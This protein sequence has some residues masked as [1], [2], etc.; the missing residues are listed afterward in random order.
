MSTVVDNDKYIINGSTL[1]EIGD[2]VKGQMPKYEIVTED[3]VCYSYTPPAQQRY[4]VTLLNLTEETIQGWYQNTLPSPI[5]K[6]KIINTSKNPYGQDAYVKVDDGKKYFT[7][8]ESY[9]YSL[10]ITIRGGSTGSGIARYAFKI[11]PLNGDNYLFWD[12]NYYYPSSSSDYNDHLY[13]EEVSYERLLP[14]SNFLVSDIAQKI[15]SLPSLSVAQIDFIKMSS[16]GT[17]SSSTDGT[18]LLTTMGIKDI[19]DIYYIIGY[20]GYSHSYSSSLK[21]LVYLDMVNNPNPVKTSTYAG[22]TINYYQFYCLPQ[23]S[24]SSGQNPKAKPYVSW[25]YWK[26]QNCFLNDTSA[27]QKLAEDSNGYPAFVMVIHKPTSSS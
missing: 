11:Y 8:N 15:A 10:P 5:T 23:T 21:G 6:V 14:K 19:S 16:K 12:S 22:Q 20:N 17:Q 18:N 3:V 26:S 25:A 9:T 27:A 24:S 1:S 7:L 13:K 2:A 4:D